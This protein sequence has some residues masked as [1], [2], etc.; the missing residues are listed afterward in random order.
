MNKKQKQ[1]KYCDKPFTKDYNN[2]VY[3]SDH[4]KERMT[5]IKKRLRQKQIHNTLVPRICKMCKKKF[6]FHGMKKNCEDCLLL[7]KEKPHLY[8]SYQK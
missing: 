2:Q 6:K 3:C 8:R 5:K 4:C 1:C 7:L